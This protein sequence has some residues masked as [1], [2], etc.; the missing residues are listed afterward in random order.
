MESWASPSAW[1]RLLGAMGWRCERTTNCLRARS[2]A[3]AEEGGGNETEGGTHQVRPLCTPD[4]GVNVLVPSG[5]H[6]P[7]MR[8]GVAAATSG[9]ANLRSTCKLA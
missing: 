3:S 9:G 8:K 5:V 2:C 7:T 4:A 1:V 6:D